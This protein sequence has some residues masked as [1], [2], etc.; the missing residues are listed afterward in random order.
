VCNHGLIIFD[1]SRSMVCICQLV[2]NHGLIWTTPE[3]YEFLEHLRNPWFFDGSRSP[4]A[5]VF[6]EKNGSTAV[7]YE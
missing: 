3:I 1:G 2:C 4:G 5:K 6:K 7:F